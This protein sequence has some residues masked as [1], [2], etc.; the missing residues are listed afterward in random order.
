[1]KKNLLTLATLGALASMSGLASAQ[2]NI[3]VY[4]VVDGAVRTANHANADGDRLN[5]ASNGVLSESRLGF[6]GSEDLGNGTRAIFQLE[7][8]FSISD[9]ETSDNRDGRRLFGRTAMVGVSNDTYGTL[10][11]G[12]QNTLGYDF[13]ISTDVYGVAHDL[14]IAGYQAV[15]TGYRW[16]NS[17]KYVNNFGGMNVGAQ[18]SSGNTI[19]ST[20]TDSAYAVNVGYRMNALNVQALYQQANDTRE[21]LL[22]NVRGEKQKLAALGSTYDFGKTQV[23]GQYFHNKYNVSDQVNKIAVLGAS[24]EVAPKVTLKGSVTYDKQNNFNEGHRNT[25]SAVVAYNLSKRTD[26]YAEVDYNKFSGQYRNSVYSLNT[27]ENPN[28]NSTGVS[29]GMRHMF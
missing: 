19:G 1:M 25:Y 15:L 11:F 3:T 16:D 20:S 14:S 4:G 2:S 23:F 5:E 18:V 26:L 9:G 27:V 17:V 24:H 7:T 10:T 22:G 6:K 29:L 13:G 8:G 21:G 12:R 28:T